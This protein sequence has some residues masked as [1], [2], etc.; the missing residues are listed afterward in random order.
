MD[1]VLCFTSISGVHCTTDLD[2]HPIL[3]SRAMHLW[4]ASIIFI[5]FFPL[6]R[7]R[8]FMCIFVCSIKSQT[9]ALPNMLM[10]VYGAG[11]R[12][13]CDGNF[14]ASN[15]YVYEGATIVV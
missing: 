7:V 4:I 3:F 2:H 6:L 1:L 10:R 11:V 15:I 13:V 5:C 14:L 8:I 12:W 9:N